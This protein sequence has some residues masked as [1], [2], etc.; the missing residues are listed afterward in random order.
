MPSYCH[1][2][3]MCRRPFHNAK[4]ATTLTKLKTGR[5]FCRLFYLVGCM[6][7]V[8]TLHASHL[9]GGELR[10]VFAGENLSNRTNTYLVQLTYYRYCEPGTA[11]FNS[12][13]PMAVC[14]DSS[15]HPNYKKSVYNVS[16][17]TVSSLF[18]H[19]A[20]ADTSCN[21]NTHD[22]IEKAIY[23][24]Y[25]TLSKDTTWHLLIYDVS[26][27]SSI[28]NLL[29]PD[30]VGMIFYCI[31]PAGINNSSP[32]FNNTAI[33]FVCMNDTVMLYNTASDADGDSLV[34]QFARPYGYHPNTTT[35]ISFVN[36]VSGAFYYLFPLPIVPYAPGYSSVQPFGLNSLSTIQSNSGATTLKIPNQG[37]YV[38]AVEIKEYRSGQLISISRRDLQLVCLACPANHAPVLQS[39]TVLTNIMTEGETL[40]FPITFNDV[41]N[42]LITLK[43]VG[44]I[45]DTTKTNPAAHL[46][47]Q[48]SSNGIATALFC[49]E[50]TCGQYAVD[51]YI[52]TVEASDNGCPSKLTSQIFSV[53]VD[54]L[55]HVP[56]PV[57]SI[58]VKPDSATCEKTPLVFTALS[59]YAGS[60]PYY[61]WFVNGIPINQHSKKITLNS[62]HDNDSVF[63]MLQSNSSCVTQSTGISDV[64]YIK[65][66]ESAK[67]NF[68]ATPTESDIFFPNITF[69]NLSFNAAHYLWDFGDGDASR[70][71]SPIH[72]YQHP[73]NYPV[74]LIV[75]S[76]DAC[77][78]QTMKEITISEAQTIYIPNS[79][80]PNND[81]MNDYFQ[82]VGANLPT[83]ELKIFTRWGQLLFS[84][85]GYPKWDGNYK[86]NHVNQGIY[87]FS[88]QINYPSKK[89]ITGNVMVIR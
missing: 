3:N 50:T 45:F 11:P 52:F 86:N 34:F 21:F 37:F 53:A 26:R 24:T 68:E 55:P 29:Q 35:N 18:I 28:V 2:V 36:N 16:L 19:P 76:K 46:Q 70:I 88:L 69:T 38:I 63:V 74:T 79:F 27:N 44:D 41:D 22:C 54:S 77:I 67:A 43:G 87:I 25:I 32:A 83:Y 65:Q 73:G 40:C 17:P 75:T 84:G 60:A 30:S 33:P 58:E 42:N 9:M 56:Q 82:P 5:C 85:S 13:Y 12:I 39:T 15:T 20:A 66:K 8:S 7:F 72:I 89:N 57:V 4:L 64:I 31:I 14:A 10:Y 78:D 1:T 61:D 48:I 71:K 80:T 47:L 49:W 62:L 81:G 23:Q 51:P 6:L 59:G